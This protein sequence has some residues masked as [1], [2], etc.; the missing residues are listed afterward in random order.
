MTPTSPVVVAYGGGRDSTAMLVRMVKTGWRPDAIVFANVGS[1]KRETYDYIRLFDGWLR[2][3]D[4]PGVTVVKYTPA[5]A[6]YHTLEGNMVL[7]ATLP[8]A[9]LNQHTCAMKFKI[10]PQVKWANNWKPAREAWARGEK[11]RKL[12]GFEAGESYRVKRADG[13]AHSGKA[14]PLEAKRYSYETPLIE[15]GMDLDACIAEIES[16]GLPVP[17]KSACYF[18]P[19]QQTEEVDALSAEDRSRL[20]MIELTAEPY[21]TKVRGLWRRPRKGDGRPGSITEY[22][23]EKKLDFVPLAELADVVVLNDK[24]QKAR[25]GETFR[26]PHVG[27]TLREKLEAAGETVPAV[28]TREY[29]DGRGRVYQEDRREVPAELED[30]LHAELIEAVA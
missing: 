10:E 30:E 5:R 17:I 4:F 25:N 28:V 3:H 15:W 27:P 23:L 9:A 11:V 26:G 21:N 18:C 20:I 7:N 22:I 24:C 6:P 16:V 13:R 2:R 8:G 1:E 12:I 14:N 19:F 29:W